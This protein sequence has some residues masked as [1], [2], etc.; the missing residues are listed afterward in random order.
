MARLAEECALSGV[1]CVSCIKTKSG[2]RFCNVTRSAGRQWESKE[3]MVFKTLI[4]SLLSNKLEALE[5]YC[6]VRRRENYL[7]ICKTFRCSI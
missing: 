5:S 2:S 7:G 1:N 4:Y 6:V 3:I